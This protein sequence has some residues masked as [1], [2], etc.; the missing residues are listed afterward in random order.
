MQSTVRYIFGRLRLLSPGRG[1]NGGDGNG[2]AP[3]LRGGLL[4][5]WPEGWPSL[6]PMQHQ[7]HHGHMLVLLDG[8][9]TC[10]A[11][12]WD[13]DRTGDMDPELFHIEFDD[14]DE[15]DMNSAELHHAIQLAQE[16]GYASAAEDGEEGDG[17][18]G[19][20]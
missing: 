6:S 10:R 14:G 1:G 12:C 5:Q 3:K 19:I 9:R 8:L 11:A 16:R 2:G 18:M 20:A 4:R 7:T 15:M 13:H 17:A